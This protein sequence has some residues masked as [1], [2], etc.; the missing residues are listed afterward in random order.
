MK[1]MFYFFFLTVLLLLRHKIRKN[2]K[3]CLRE[4]CKLFRTESISHNTTENIF[5]S[6]L[7]KKKKRNQGYGVK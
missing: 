5:K 2:V 6:L 4:C 1:A 3:Q 7:K